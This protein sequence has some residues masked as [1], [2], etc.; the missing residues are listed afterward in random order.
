MTSNDI[1]TFDSERLKQGDGEYIWKD[2]T[3][4][5][6]ETLKIIAKYSGNF[7]DGKK[8]GKGTMKYPND[9]EYVGEWK[10]NNMHGTGTYIYKNGDVYSGSWVDNK[11][12]G[13]GMYQFSK[14]DNSKLVGTWENGEIVS[15]S[16]ILENYAE[17]IGN[18]KMSRPYGEGKFVYN[19][20]ITQTGK[21][22]EAKVSTEEEGEVD[23]TKPPSVK[24]NGNSIVSF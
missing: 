3:S 2:K 22:E 18:F 9:D 23:P 6:D 17:Y 1:G 14:P 21:Y 19:S 7:K 10:D 8:D 12:S 20:G 11:K 4:A 5:E 15:G 13:Q 16:W 24:W